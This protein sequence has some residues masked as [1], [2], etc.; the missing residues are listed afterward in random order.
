[1]T[2]KSLLIALDFP[3]LFHHCQLEPLTDSNQRV[4]VDWRV[5]QCPLAMLLGD[6]PVSYVQS[7]YWAFCSPGR[8]SCFKTTFSVNSWDLDVGYLLIYENISNLCELKTLPISV[9]EF[10][11]MWLASKTIL[12]FYFIIYI[13][14]STY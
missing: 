11:G 12:D 2:P 8:A 7:S 14:N 9:Q 3:L 13:N 10:L 1:M 4:L 6:F 5:F